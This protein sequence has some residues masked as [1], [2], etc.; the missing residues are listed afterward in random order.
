M[1]LLVML[2]ID[3]SFLAHEVLH[4]NLNFKHCSRELL[5]EIGQLS[6]GEAIDSCGLSLVRVH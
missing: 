3:Y 6:L 2:S 1:L 4:G 5:M